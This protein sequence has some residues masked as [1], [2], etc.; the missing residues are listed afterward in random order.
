M[1]KYLA[2]ARAALLDAIQ[3]KAEI[4]I[5]VVLDAI[6]IFV[7]GSLWLANREHLVSMSLSQIVTYY[8]MVLVISRMIEFYFDEDMSDMVQSG[9][10]SKYLLKPIHFPFAFI[11][12]TFGRKLISGIVMA[13]PMLLIVGTVFRHYLTFPNRLMFGFFLLSL[14]ITIGVRYSVSVL[15]GAGAFFWERSE[16]LTHARWML[17]MTIGGYLLP[18]TF[19]PSW[20]RII[21][22]ILPFKY[23]YYVPVSIFTGTFDVSTTLSAL[24][25]GTLWLLVIIPASHWVWKK[26]ISRYSSVGG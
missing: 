5:W 24:A 16:A 11:P 3:E 23:I 8:I 19:Y 10:F 1:R 22:E 14:L 6:P 18:L 17:E 7:M 25:I 12:L 15:A 4:M 2:L 13:I 21:P 9:E 26:G 20:F